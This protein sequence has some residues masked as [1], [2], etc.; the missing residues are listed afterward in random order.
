[1][2]SSETTTVSTVY[3]GVDASIDLVMAVTSAAFTRE[4]KSVASWSAYSL[5]LIRQILTHQLLY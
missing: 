3:D 1:M 4:A 5:I 2:P